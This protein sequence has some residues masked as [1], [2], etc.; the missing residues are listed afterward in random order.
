MAR[1]LT[2]SEK[3]ELTRSVNR[4]RREAV[5]WADEYDRLLPQPLKDFPTTDNA[6]DLTIAATY[7]LFAAGCVYAHCQ[8]LLGEKLGGPKAANKWLEQRRDAS[9]S[10]NALKDRRDWITH[11]AIDRHPDYQLV[12]SMVR[13]PDKTL[14]EAFEEA[15]LTGRATVDET[16]QLR[17]TDGYGKPAEEISQWQRLVVQELQQ[18]V[19][20]VHQID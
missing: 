3:N 6:D 18:M 2:L 12:F 10:L 17:W 15:K 16:I 4:W 14:Q 20:D 9:L 5:R 1:P 13:G 11:G 8:S 7:F 19:E